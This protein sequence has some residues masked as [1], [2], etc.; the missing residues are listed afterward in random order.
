MDWLGPLGQ[1]LLREHGVLLPPNAHFHIPLAGDAR[2]GTLLTGWG[3]DDVFAAWRWGRAVAVLSG[4]AAGRPRDIARI[5]HLAAPWAVRGALFRRRIDR[6]LPAWLRPRGRRAALARWLADEHEKPRRWDRWVAR[7]LRLRY[8]LLV[9]RGY[10]TVGRLA[11]AELA[12]PLLAPGFV[13]A[14]AR[15]GG[16]VGWPDRTAAMTALFSDLLPRSLLERSTKAVFDKAF[17][18]PF[19]R[20]F[21]RTWDGSGVDHDLVDAE[22]LRDEWLDPH[23]DARS[24]LLLQSAWLASQA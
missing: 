7:V 2:G 20:E 13:A 4:H 24:A 19:T 11:G 3:G 16:A 22:L 8:V 5:A 9:R 1:P 14:L 18:G 21:A 12:H 17:W 23:P 6:L 10:D 15:R